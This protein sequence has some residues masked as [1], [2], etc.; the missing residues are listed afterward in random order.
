MHSYVAVPQGKTAYL[1]EVVSGAPALIADHAGAT[2]RAVVGRA[3]VERR[4]L[5]RRMLLRI[6]CARSWLRKCMSKAIA[7]QQHDTGQVAKE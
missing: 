5:V 7:V 1:S 6:I 2:R 4:S 3:K